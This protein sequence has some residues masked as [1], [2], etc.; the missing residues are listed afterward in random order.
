M[1][2]RYTNWRTRREGE[3][4]EIQVPNGGHNTHVQSE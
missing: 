3:G 2:V 4:T 1:L